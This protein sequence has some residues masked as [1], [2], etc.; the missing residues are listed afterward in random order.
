MPRRAVLATVDVVSEPE[1]ARELFLFISYREGPLC[2]ETQNHP[3]AH[4]VPSP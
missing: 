1:R 3:E 2:L 4:S